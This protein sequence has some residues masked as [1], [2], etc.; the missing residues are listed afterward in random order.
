MNAGPIQFRRAS[1]SAADNAVDHIPDRQALGRGVA[2][3]TAFEQWVDRRAEIS[4]EH[5]RKRCVRWHDSLGRK[6]HDQ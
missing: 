2:A 6:S 5:E 4:P 3:H 1:A